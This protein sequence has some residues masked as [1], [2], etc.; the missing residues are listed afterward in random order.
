[1]KEHHAKRGPSGASSLF[2]VL[3]LSL[4]FLLAALLVLVQR[5]IYGL[6]TRVALFVRDI[7]R[8]EGLFCP[9]LFGRPYPD[10]P[11]L[12]FLLSAPFCLLMG[13]ICALCISV[14]SLLGA[15]ALL[16][17][18]FQF[19]RRHLGESFALVSSLILLSTPE[20][21]LKAERATL[22]MLL[23]LSVF[24]SNMFLFQGF[25]EEEGKSRV[26]KGLGFLF[27]ALSYLVK[28]P[29]GIVLCTLPLS[30]FLALKRDVRRLFIFFLY[31]VLT[32]GLVIGLHFLGLFFQGG[33]EL[34]FR[35]LD[36]QFIS[37]ISGKA[38]KPFY[39]YFFYLFG[40]FSPWLLLI[41]A[42]CLKRARSCIRQRYDCFSGQD[43]NI[44]VAIMAL[45]TILPF[46]FATS[47]HGRYLLPAF[48]AI[49]IILSCLLLKERDPRNITKPLNVITRNWKK[50]FFFAGLLLLLFFIIMSGMDL[51]ILLT[52]LLLFVAVFA[53]SRYLFGK[54]SGHVRPVLSYGVLVFF[55][56]SGLAITLEPQVSRR[57]S[58]RQFVQETEKAV[59]SALGVY[60]F[61][62]KPDGEGLKY[63]LFSRYYPGRITFFKDESMVRTLP[64]GAIMVVYERDMK[65][66]SK[67]LKKRKYKII[68]EG[69][70]HNRKVYSLLFKG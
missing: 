11:P 63:C 45:G 19:T 66:I 23:A 29:V 48:P 37:R 3:F 10:Y 41:G 39:F 16:V 42:L 44:F 58:G 61:R 35:V 56:T 49:S 46:L 32:G 4:L 43:F 52:L 2:F 69:Y 26:K 27:M 62:L 31:T 20:F 70:I 54:V 9:T 55:I 40:A 14:P 47:R 60:L 1:M 7:L 22:D 68:S 50:L 24:S 25:W 5:D 6:E 38:N 57:E 21:F 30:A 8:G 64:E 67:D 13:R 17:L 34:V 33:E 12:Y 18:V 15:T 36:A 59:K 51:T 65:R 28:G 53:V